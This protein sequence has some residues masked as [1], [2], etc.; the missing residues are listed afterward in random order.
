MSSV[1]HTIR[2]KC[3][4][5]GINNLVISVNI[6]KAKSLGR[7]E[8]AAQVTFQRQNFSTIDTDSLPDSITTLYRRIPRADTCGVGT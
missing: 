4:K 1:T 5:D 8:Q 3:A 6:L 2:R 7:L